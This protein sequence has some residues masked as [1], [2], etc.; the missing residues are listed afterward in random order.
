MS[1]VYTADGNHSDSKMDKIYKIAKKSRDVEDRK[2]VP[3]FHIIGKG[4]NRTSIDSIVKTEHSFKKVKKLIGDDNDKLRIAAILWYWLKSK[5]IGEQDKLFESVRNVL[6]ESEANSR[7]GFTD[8]VNKYIDAMPAEYRKDV[9]YYNMQIKY[10]EMMDTIPDGFEEV[11]NNAFDF[12]PSDITYKY[13]VSLGCD[14]T[15]EEVFESIKIDVSCPL[16]CLRGTNYKVHSSFRKVDKNIF[17]KTAESEVNND[18]ILLHLMTS[19]GRHIRVKYVHPCLNADS[20]SLLTVNM[21]GAG[22]DQS[23]YDRDEDND[24]ED[25]DTNQ[26]STT[27]YL[28]FSL[29]LGVKG[30]NEK[31]VVSLLKRSFGNLGEKSIV[32]FKGSF[33]LVNELIEY[34]LFLH[35]L[36]RHDTFRYFFYPNE[37]Q[38]YKQRYEKTHKNFHYSN[39]K[40]HTMI[41]FSSIQYSRLVDRFV[42]NGQ[43]VEKNKGTIFIRVKF[44]R[45]D[46]RE[47]SEEAKNMLIKAIAIYNQPENKDRLIKAYKRLFG[48]EYEH[49]KPEPP[50]GKDEKQGIMTGYKRIIQ[51]KSRPRELT[52][53]ELVEFQQ[54][55]GVEV[56]KVR[57]G[58]P[59]F[60]FYKGAQVVFYMGNYY[61]SQNPET[62][63]Y[64]GLMPSNTAPYPLPSC[65]KLVPEDVIYDPDT[66]EI[67]LMPGAKVKTKTTK[68]PSS[69]L[70]LLS[71]F[72]GQ[73]NYN[74]VPPSTGPNTFLH[75]VSKALGSIKDVSD[76][77][78]ELLNYTSVLM[79]QNFDMTIE[80]VESIIKDQ[81]KYLDPLRFSR[82][83]EEWANDEFQD[84]FQFFFF[85][86]RDSEIPP[87]I[88]NHKWM[89]IKDYNIRAKAVIFVIDMNISQPQCRY[90]SS[91]S[92]SGQGKKG[93]TRSTFGSGMCHRMNKFLLDATVVQ[94]NTM[95]SSGHQLSENPHNVPKLTDIFENVP[96][97]AQKIDTYGKTRYI[98]LQ[99]G[100]VIR[101]PPAEPLNVPIVT[102][103]EINE[104]NRPSYDDVIEF[105]SDIVDEDDISLWVDSTTHSSLS[106]IGDNIDIIRGI[107]FVVDRYNDHFSILINPIKFDC[108]LH[109]Y[110][111]TDLPIV[112]TKKSTQNFDHLQRLKIIL[113]LIIRWMT[114]NWD[115]TDPKRW[116]K[117]NTKIIEGYDYSEGWIEYK[118][119]KRSKTSSKI[120]D[121]IGIVLLDSKKSRDSLISLIK[122]H[123]SKNRPLPDHLLPEPYVDIGR[124]II[125]I[126][127]TAELRRWYNNTY[128]EDHSIVYDGLEE[129]SIILDKEDANL[130]RELGKSTSIT[131]ISIYFTNPYVFRMP[132]TLYMV[133][134]VYHNEDETEDEHLQKCQTLC[135][136]WH[137]TG[138]NTGFLTVADDTKWTKTATE[139]WSGIFTKP[140]RVYYYTDDTTLEDGTIFEIG[141]IKFHGEYM[142]LLPLNHNGYMAREAAQE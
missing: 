115:G 39:G 112:Y 38:K 69:L 79:Q 59:S 22:T 70:T 132:T 60:T 103:T 13:E 54:G 119:K 133:Q 20:N 92:S 140:I 77:R 142:A 108:D 43:I 35:F 5:S 117:S 111:I 138:V 11:D 9:N 53:E 96:I 24:D 130:E 109:Q 66:C 128:Y 72:S 64:I 100:Y 134:R 93:T 135:A 34:P 16:I 40:Y 105:L 81:N 126:N 86:F 48:Y 121:D 71:S 37:Q 110:P 85:E 139:K 52:D 106:E 2:G 113:P 125:T 99:N 122:S 141:I 68:V 29:P 26:A 33:I 89:W 124:E 91:K 56:R 17:D 116:I 95:S 84:T 114:D 18:T 50:K 90:V 80:E 1:I 127:T 65:K 12:E 67:K 49:K 8:I 78:Q 15:I 63:P 55:I 19:N 137:R 107:Y 82:A 7:L 30:V 41:T 101:T 83:V 51:G 136:N 104:D 21:R 118:R 76:I 47:I 31:Q 46:N 14:I 62:H 97:V 57:R 4:K 45:A 58:K 42:K 44:S 131:D 61:T 23:D 75:A 36:A 123:I 102:D 27:P 6:S 3:F 98:Q 87:L 94:E 129:L 10:R 74:L 120:H 88:P 25:I 73:S 28:I 32:K